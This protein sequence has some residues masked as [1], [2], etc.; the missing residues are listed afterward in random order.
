[1]TAHTISQNLKNVA[2]RTF[3]KSESKLFVIPAWNQRLLKE[4]SSRRL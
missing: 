2:F 3:E 1:M 4:W